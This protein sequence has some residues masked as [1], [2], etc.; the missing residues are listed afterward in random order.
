MP[1]SAKRR[2]TSQSN[3]STNEL[4]ETRAELDFAKIQIAGTRAEL[5]EA[6]IQIA[7]LE[8]YW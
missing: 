6:K 4:A 2:R 7:S 3:R 5:N 1:K 8:V